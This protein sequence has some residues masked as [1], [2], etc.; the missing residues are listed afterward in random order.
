[1]EKKPEVSRTLQQQM[2]QESVQDSYNFLS[3]IVLQ[4]YQQKIVVIQDS[5]QKDQ[6]ASY[7]FQTMNYNPIINTDLYFSPQ[8]SLKMEEAATNTRSLVVFVLLHF[9]LLSQNQL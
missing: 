5:R 1:M 4:N 3:I 8:T 7:L 6:I 9:Q 2:V